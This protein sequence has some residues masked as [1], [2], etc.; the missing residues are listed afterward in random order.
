MEGEERAA[1][2]FLMAYLADREAGRELG[3]EHY[4]ERFPDDAALVRSE[5]QRLQDEAA[6]ETESGFRAGWQPSPGGALERGRRIGGY[7]VE[8]ELGRGG[9]AVVFLARDTRLP[10]LVALKVLR[11][12]DSVPLGQ[13]L[14]R[15]QREA[16]AVSRLDHPGICSIYEIGEDGGA[17]F[18][19]MRYV[20]GETMS[21]LIRAGRDASAGD[22]PPAPLGPRRPDRVALIL[23]WFIAL[24]EA[25]EAAHQAGIR[26]RDVKPANILISERGDPVLLDFGLASDE[27]SAGGTLTGSG[28]ALGTPAYMA[29]EQILAAPTS[30]R[31]DVYGLGVSL[32][33]ALALELPFHAATREGL[34][35]KILGQSPPDIRRRARDVS[36]DLAAVLEV[37]LA[38]DSEQ[39]YESCAALAADLRNVREGRPVSVKLASA[40][41][42]VLRWARRHPGTAVPLLVTFVVLAVGLVWT[43]STNREL[44]AAYSDLSD[45]ERQA[46]LRLEQVK[47]LSDAVVLEELEQRAEQLWPALP[48]RADE[49]KLW[50]RDAQELLARADTHR[51]ALEE[52]RTHAL[53]YGEAERRAEYAAELNRIAELEDELRAIVEAPAAE[54]PELEQQELVRRQVRVEEQ[55]A[56]LSAA[57]EQARGWRFHEPD[58]AWEHGVLSRLVVDLEA[59]ADP[60]HGTVASVRRRLEFAEELT[61]RS[62]DEPQAAWLAAERYAASDARYLHVAEIGLAPQVGLVPLGPDPD[63]GLLEFLHLATHGEGEPPTRDAAGHLV[64]DESTGVILVLVPGGTFWM[65]SQKHDPDGPN[66]SLLTVGTNSRPVHEV[67][68][69]PFFISKYELT[70]HQWMALT[71]ANPMEALDGVP[72]MDADHQ[73][74]I[75]P[76]AQVSWNDCVAEL[77]RVDLDL[78]TEPQWEYACRAGTETA[79][80]SGDDVLSLEGFANVADVNAGRRYPPGF[81]HDPELDDGWVEDAPVGSFGANRF[82][83]HDVH[84]NVAEWCLDSYEHFLSLPRSGDLP[85]TTTASSPEDRMIRGGMNAAPGLPAASF[86][87]LVGRSDRVDHQTGCRPVRRLR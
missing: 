10:R 50:L 76:V 3:L 83:L 21:H 19:A 53:P 42:R 68:L 41:T 48:D 11:A 22:D 35:R 74:L 12:F 25:L 54:L 18:I 47:R 80:F 31:T 67:T 37:A 62:I 40:H 58:R 61:P 65:G 7:V 77:R 75:H 56:L 64:R 87:R 30:A 52:V 26:H 46:S 49:L 6:A 15:F 27:S 16:E 82:G 57:V 2:R 20:P 63:S 23:G 79:F 32:Y 59:F 36:D 5:Y 28:D 39:R 69:R 1:N 70:Q 14:A 29:P 9:Q 84:G 72:P 38:K 24:A 78:P 8:R 45:Q 51:A 71:G 60:E 55:L 33:E 34:Y 44:E 73:G 4:L 13:A 86:Y 43:L 81:P 66:H 17:L 85:I